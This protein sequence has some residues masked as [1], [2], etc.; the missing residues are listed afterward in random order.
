VE[1]WRV[2]ATALFGAAC[3]V[4]VPAV[5][6][7]VRDSTRSAGQTAL[8]GAIT[9]TAVSVLGVVMVTVLPAVPTWLM[10]AAVAAAAAVLLLA[11]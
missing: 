5:M 1:T 2:V 6:A 7:K 9:L 11:N 3:L 8:S 10:V 4:L